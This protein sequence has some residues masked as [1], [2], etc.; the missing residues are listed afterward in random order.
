MLAPTWK[1]DGGR[2]LHISPQGS[3]AFAEGRLS[4]I[5]RRSWFC[6]HNLLT[7]D[8]ILNSH[9]RP[10]IQSWAAPGSVPHSY[11]GGTP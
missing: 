1:K 2:R 11:G 8:F 5:C 6:Q 7:T 3:S 9:P 10:Y 4:A